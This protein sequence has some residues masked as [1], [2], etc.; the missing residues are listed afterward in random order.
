ML[1]VTLETVVV[2]GTGTDL[3]DRILDKDGSADKQDADLTTA[4]ADAFPDPTDLNVAYQRM[5]KLAGSDFDRFGM[6]ASGLGDLIASRYGQRLRAEQ[7]GRQRDYYVGEKSSMLWRPE[8]GDLTR[9][10]DRLAE[11]LNAESKRLWPEGNPKDSSDDLVERKAAR[12]KKRGQSLLDP[13]TLNT[14]MF[15]ATE[16]YGLRVVAEE[17]FDAQVGLLAVGGGKVLELNTD[18]G[19]VR[20]RDRRL[21]DLCRSAAAVPWDPEILKTPPDLIKQFVETFM[22]EDDPWGAFHRKM[23][24]Y[25]SNLQGGNPQRYVVIVRGGTT[26]G[27]SQE[28]NSL[29]ACLG[30]Y[31][32]GSPMSIFKENQGDKPR[33]D[34]LRVQRKRYVFIA[35]AAKKWKL[36]GSQL[37]RMAGTDSD[38]QRGM[39]SGVFHDRANQSLAI[40]SANEMPTIL[41]IDAAARRRLLVP[42]MDQTLSSDK[43]DTTIR[44]RFRNSELV[45][46]YQLAA[47]V[48][49]FQDFWTNPSAADADLRKHYG[50]TSDRMEYRQLHGLSPFLDW[51]M[52]GTDGEPG[53]L[54]KMSEEDMSKRGAKSKYVSYAELHQEYVTWLKLYGSA[55][56]ERNRLSQEDFNARLE[57][58]HDFKRVKS[59]AWRWEGWVLDPAPID[60]QQLRHEAN[61]V[62]EK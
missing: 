34:I 62:R 23:K 53:R 39:H 5:L 54:T 4:N 12:L 44:D 14:A 11:E 41:G 22:P 40:I 57:A 45:Q 16:R 27:K 46:M 17:V 37:K 6:G 20:M 2:T 24:L 49:G 35:E 21:E 7:R 30:G 10:G 28:A 52:F 25:G 47:L 60:W 13:K 8:M 31:A 48:K 15:I 29:Q 33:A 42:T 19:T 58:D 18:G 9:F 36:D 32:I 59:G 51:L 38:P 61:R 43:E 3:L 26:S 56:D 55:E 50:L 1:E